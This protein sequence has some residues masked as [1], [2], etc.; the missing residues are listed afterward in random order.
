M[1]HERALWPGGTISLGPHWHKEN[2]LVLLIATS[3]TGNWSLK[4]NT[5][6][7]TKLH[8]I[9]NNKLAQ[10][11]LELSQFST[12]QKFLKLITQCCQNTIYTSFLIRMTSLRT[13]M[14]IADNTVLSR[15]YPHIIL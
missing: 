2:R 1:A 11:K 7:E 5:H 4:H 15:H 6:S 14:F 10:L 3:S 8:R 9:I 12:S 13:W